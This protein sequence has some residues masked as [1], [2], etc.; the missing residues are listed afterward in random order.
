MPFNWKEYLSLA[1]FLQGRANNYSQEASF[2]CAA[3]R[4][5]YAAFCHARNYARD[6]HGFEPTY[7]YD[8]H[9]L[10]R[11]DF[12][13]WQ[14]TNISDWLLRLRQWRNACDYRDTVSNLSRLCTSAIN[15]A[16]KVFDALQPTIPLGQSTQEGEE[17]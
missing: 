8:D 14:M 10:V 4:A 17:E 15:L 6:W 11:E 5:Y 1:L 16:Q 7:D 2:R 9:K 3:S 12:R 13:N